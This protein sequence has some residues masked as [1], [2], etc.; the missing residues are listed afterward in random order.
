MGSEGHCSDGPPSK[1]TGGAPY[2]MTAHVYVID[3]ASGEV[4]LEVAVPGRVGALAWNPEGT[5]VATACFKDPFLRILDAIAGT[6]ELEQ[7]LGDGKQNVNCVAWSPDGLKVAAGTDSSLY[8]LD[9]MTGRELQNHEECNGLEM[10]A[11]DPSGTNIAQSAQVSMVTGSC[12]TLRVIDATGKVAW[13]KNGGPGRL[14]DRLSWHPDGTKLAFTCGGEVCI[15]NAATGDLSGPYF[16]LCDVMYGSLN[17]IA[18]DFTGT[19]I[20]TGRDKLNVVDASSG[21]VEVELDRKVRA[22]AWIPARS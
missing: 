7:A 2:F 19:K 10:V 8:V 9:A 5:K 6:M 14:P 11:W 17:D 21:A 15:R 1:T 18:F 12:K 4:T 22:V 20:A 3:I 13:Q 16:R